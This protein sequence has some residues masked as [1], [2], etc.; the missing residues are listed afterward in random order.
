MNSK[1]KNIFENEKKGI[2]HSLVVSSNSYTLMLQN[3]FKSSSFYLGNI[4]IPVMTVFSCSI[5]FPITFSFI[6]ML[7]ISM[8]FTSFSSYG[9]LF[10]TI[11]KS[12][13]MKN[14]NL[15]MNESASL[16]IATLLIILT[17]TFITLGVILGSLAILDSLGMVSHSWF[18]ETPTT[19]TAQHINWKNIWWEM[20]FY[21]WFLQALIAFSISFVIENLL[22]TQKNYFIVIFIYMLAGF[23]FGG[24]M[25]GTLDTDGTGS[26]TVITDEQ[27]DSWFETGSPKS[28]GII[29]PYQWGH[30]MWFVSQLWPHYG[31]NQMAFNIMK[32][33]TY[34]IDEPLSQWSNARFFTEI[35]NSKV[36]YYMIT[37]YAY[38]AFFLWLG[39]NL[40]RYKKD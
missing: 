12:T 18:Y 1:A 24:I 29:I 13:M 25:S 21:Y 2:M 33:G 37:P 6:W 32:A 38:I 34:S 28:Q 40:N 22:S 35:N 30:P 31:L 11:K 3:H 19:E 36:I 15:T 14:I 17:T 9:T 5:L 7:F 10:F 4:L 16:Y 8:A 26:I 23:F 20:L 27:I 39:G